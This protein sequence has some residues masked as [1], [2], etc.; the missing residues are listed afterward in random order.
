MIS[1]SDI[2]YIC[3]Q[4]DIM[5][6]KSRGQNFLIDEKIVDKIITASDLN[7]KDVVVEVGPGLGVLTHELI[8]K[9]KKVIAVE[10]DYK[11]ADYLKAEFVGAPNIDIVQGDVLKINLLDLGLN[12][13]DYKIVSNLPYNI[14]SRFLRVF[15][16]MVDNS[17]QEMILM[18]QKEVAERIVAEIGEMSVLSV[19]VQFY[20]EP[21]LL[22]NVSKESFWPA[23]QVDSAV[24]S[25]KRKTAKLSADPK[26][27]FR[28]VKMGFAAKRKQLH[29]NLA[30]GL[31]KTSDEVKRAIK[32]IGFDEKIRAQDL[33]VE[34]WVRLLKNL[35]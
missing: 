22:F 9:A 27:F 28:L 17:P 23:P 6:S 8:K 1:L 3:S 16:E 15:L 35:E 21:K 32:D 10:L 13:H 14:T 25:I 31:H 30:G 20:G 2:K 24:I 29:N 11:I 33:G 12:S 26:K 4:Y 18:L 5:P 34:D 19:M 7:R